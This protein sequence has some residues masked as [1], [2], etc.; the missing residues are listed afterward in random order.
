FAAGVLHHPYRPL[1]DFW[2]KL[3]VLVHGSIL[4]R[5]GASAKPGAVQTP[6][7]RSDRVS[8]ASLLRCV[9]PIER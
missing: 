3:A 5:V 8:S 4:S 6:P 7:S 9:I 1:A 2:G